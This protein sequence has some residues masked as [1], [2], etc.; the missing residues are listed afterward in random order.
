MSDPGS[1]FSNAVTCAVHTAHVTSQS[2]GLGGTHG[3]LRCMVQHLTRL[4][5]VG[6]RLGWQGLAPSW[7]QVL[8]QVTATFC[9]IVFDATL[10]QWS[11]CPPTHA[12][13]S[14]PGTRRNGPALTNITTV[15][16]S[17]LTDSPTSTMAPK[18]QHCVWLCTHTHTTC[19]TSH[20]QHHTE[21]HALPLAATPNR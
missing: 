5:R 9:V 4:R 11:C 15:Q 7:D 13:P 18:A 21:P 3:S 8:L 17:A 6:W 2:H 19:R 12:Q 10:A 1:C 16:H 14:L 20:W